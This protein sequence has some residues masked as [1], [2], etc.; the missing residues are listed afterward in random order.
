ML[1][2]A[3]ARLTAPSPVRIQR[4][5]LL[6]GR[7]GRSS[8][9]MRERATLLLP[10]AANSTNCHGREDEL[11]S[12]YARRLPPVAEV[13]YRILLRCHLTPSFSMYPLQ[14]TPFAVV[15]P[16]FLPESRVTHLC[17]NLLVRGH[18]G[19]PQSFAKGQRETASPR[20]ARSV[21]SFQRGSSAPAATDAVRT[22]SMHRVQLRRN[23]SALPFRLASVCG[24]LLE[25]PEVRTELFYDYNN[26]RSGDEYFSGRPLS[27][28]YVFSSNEVVPNGADSTPRSPGKGQI[29]ET[30]VDIPYIGNNETKNIMV[31]IR[32]RPHVARP[33]KR[34]GDERLLEARYFDRLRQPL[35]VRGGRG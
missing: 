29:K 33:V 22:H 19:P 10:A 24:Q 16:G 3:Q 34:A 13:T 32:I 18:R 20:A 2:E 30:N 25:I 26:D 23:P 17:S 12:T 6:T 1:R 15:Y 35:A 11:Q 8:A 27:C 28:Q 4:A 7:A 31:H 21:S 5:W 14:N 9:T